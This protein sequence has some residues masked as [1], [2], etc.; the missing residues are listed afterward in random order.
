M[1]K[2]IALYASIMLN[3]ALLFAV[4]LAIAILARGPRV[5]TRT[6][7]LHPFVPTAE[8]YHQDMGLPVEYMLEK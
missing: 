3:I 8:E 7:Y 1:N 2:T 4:G 5:E 6:I